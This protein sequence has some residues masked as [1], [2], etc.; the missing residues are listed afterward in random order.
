MIYSGIALDY[1]GCHQTD[2]GRGHQGTPSVIKFALA[3][4]A[5]EK[6]SW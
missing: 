1:Q 5:L 6:A 2:H 3:A 4:T